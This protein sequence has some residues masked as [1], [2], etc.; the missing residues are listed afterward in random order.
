MTDPLCSTGWSVVPSFTPHAPTS[1]L[2]LLFDEVGLTQ[3]AGDPPVAWQTPW[4]EMADVEVVRAQRSVTVAATVGGVRYTWTTKDVR[5][6]DQVCAFVTQHAGGVERRRRS[7]G[8]LVAVAVIVLVASLA[9][10]I[11]AWINGSTTSVNELAMAR[12]INLSQKDLPDAFA[13]LADATVSPLSAIFPAANQV[14]TSTTKAPVTT[15]TTKSDLVFTQAA[16][17]FQNCLGVSAQ[18]DRVYGQAG[19]QP[20]V[21]VSSKIYSAAT[22]GGIEV[23]STSQYYATTTMVRRD[24]KEMSHPDFGSC[25][26]TSNAAIILSAFAKPQPTSNIATNWQPLTFVKGWSRGGVAAVDLPYG[27]GSLHLVMVVMTSEHYE[28]T[29]GVLVNH[30][31]DAQVFTSNLVDTMLARM[32]SDSARAV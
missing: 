12:S 15:T 2:T 18:R 13:P 23:A 31:S 16:T 10:A 1:D 25:F 29:L 3:L 17:L 19:Q 24:T 22:Y 21:Q 28:V 6:A 20:D 7:R 8:A 32:T 11:G 9:G 30:W 5:D 27:I 4:A 14:I 26:T